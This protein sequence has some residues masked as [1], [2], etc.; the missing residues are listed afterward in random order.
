[1]FG[2]V[3]PRELQG[4]SRGFPTFLECM[5]SMKYLGVHELFLLTIDEQW[6]V[7]IINIQILIASLCHQVNS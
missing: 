4:R 7:E 5:W 6:T 1:M 3:G 2:D